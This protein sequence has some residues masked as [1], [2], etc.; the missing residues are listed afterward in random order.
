M[1]TAFPSITVQNKLPIPFVLYDAFQT[2]P[3]APINPA[4]IFGTLTPL[5]TIPS[6]ASQPVVPIHGPISTY[7][8]Y[9]TTGA[10]IAREF[11]MGDAP[12]T[13][14]IDSTDAA[15][16]TATGAFIDFITANPN[17][18]VTTSFNPLLT[19]KT[20]A[21]DVNA[22]F[23]AHAAYSSCTFVSY[24]MAIAAKAR[25]PAQPG[26]SKP[27]PAQPV[28]NAS[29]R[30]STLCNYL[31][32][33]WPQGFPDVT[34]T[35]FT[36]ST[37]NESIVVGGDIQTSDLPFAAAGAPFIRA[38][39][40][41]TVHA[42]FQFHYGLDAGVF[43][44]RIEFTLP[45]IT[46][47]TG[48]TLQK[49]TISFDISPL[50]EFA[51]FTAKA[52]MPFSLFNSPTFNADLSVVVDNIEAEVGVVID[53][54]GRSLLT[55][56][57]M[58]GV[59]F[60]Q[61]GVGMG[62]MFE[63]EALA[64]GVQGKFHIGDGSNIVTLDDDTFVVV[65]TLEGDVPN[66]VYISF[67]VPKMDLGEVITIFT[68]AS[69]SFGLPVSVTDLSFR[70]AE[71]PMKPVALPDGSLSQMGYGFSANV[72]VLGLALYGDLELGAAGVAGTLTSGPISAGPLTI[73]GNGPGVTMKVDAS[74]NPIRN[75]QIPTTKAMR[76]AIANATTKQLVPPGG[77]SLTV[78]M[79]S[80][81]L[82]LGA[83]ISLFDIVSESITA[84]VTSGGV[85]FALDYGA[86]LT[87]QMTC[88]LS[89]F[90]NFTGT[91]QYGLDTSI[92]L[93]SVAGFSLGSIPLDATCNA[94]L[95]IA[96]SA[97]DVGM[98][99]GGGFDFEGLSLS[100][101]P[102]SADVHIAKITDL[103]SSIGQYL[104]DH[105]EEIFGDL[106][107]DATKWAGLVYKGLIT[108]INDV[109]GGLKI[110][111][112]QTEAE[113]ASIMSGAGRGIDEAAAAIKN[114]FS[115][116][117][118]DVASA[119]ASGYGATAS[120]VSSALNA[121]G[122]G[123][124]DAAAAIKNAFNASANDVASALASGYNAA[125]GAVSSALNAAAYG[126]NDAAS[127]IK[128]TFNASANDVASALVSGYGATASAVS[129]AL[130]AADYGINDAAVA[131][132]SA[133]TASANDIASAL[134]SGYGATAD[135][136][137]SALNAAGYG[138]NDVAQALSSVCGAV[139]D[140]VNDILQ[141]I[142]YTTDQISD[143]F[144]TLGGDLGNFAQATWGA[145]T[146]AANPSNW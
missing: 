103:L 75:N 89:D 63:P 1:S 48:V 2:D 53:G 113:V 146:Q 84:A 106:L 17:D 46:L 4:T 97:S 122:Y 44:T 34:V 20:A 79:S 120:A 86:V 142:G 47:I 25:T 9:D 31:G 145:I 94:T 29:Y 32:G 11:T 129:S 56:P 40:P 130:N 60:D 119:L 37:A 136:V 54:N 41:S 116:A 78:A 65:C 68:N 74:G 18:P 115:G 28:Q 105:V 107:T 137:G 12:K 108:G 22:F 134:I 70:W 66:P 112:N 67:Y 76:D 111:F 114:A 52:A 27:A 80:P 13:F 45:A 72:D 144:N 93:P 57:V 10:P 104:L 30:L 6:G 3:S 7:L 100:I 98:T 26:P 125:A 81:F 24:M 77:P 95:G 36:C 15:R 59:H 58:K 61:F 82:S 35:N 99:I 16:M 117:A 62:V 42:S 132:M 133:V 109:A 101:G 23:Q 90:H 92:P 50:F 126:I 64:L 5:A 19:R 141:G 43:G 118:N 143:A 14:V 39:L 127:A 131:I 71:D 140:A 135:A 91:F 123:I 138:I 55:P 121:A 96:T 87:T 124:N 49:P 69:A 38:M 73:A 102:F 128:N 88:T 8:A 51:V 33:N 83:S 21:A 110:A 85:T 139:P